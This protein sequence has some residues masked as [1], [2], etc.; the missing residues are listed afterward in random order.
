[1]SAHRP[2]AHRPRELLAALGAF[3]PDFFQVLA[4]SMV[5]NVLM[6]VPSIYM[7]QVYDR[8]L[9]SYSELTLLA[10]SLIALFLFGV[11]AMAEWL[12]SRL[13]VRSGVR[14]DR[15]LRG[16]VFEASFAAHATQSPLATPR[17]FSD[18]MQVRQFLTGS[19]MF[20]LLDA[21]WA[22][23]YAAVAWFLH[24]TLGLLAVVFIGVQ[25][26]V[27]WVSQQRT[28]APGEAAATA[29][30]DVNRFLHAKLRNSEVMEVLGMAEPLRR[31]WQERHA[32]ALAR[33]TASQQ[34]ADSMLA[35]SKFVR[36][37]LQAL[38]L[39]AGALLVIDG[40][41]SAGAMIAANLLIARA[42]A[43][44]DQLVAVWRGFTGTRL[45]FGRLDALL[46]AFPA[47]VATAVPAA[48][49]G[50]VKLRDVTARVPGREAPILADIALELA[51][52]TLTV[53]LGPSGSG[54]STLARVLLGAW[55]QVQGEVLLDGEPVAALDRELLA[56]HVG[57]LPQEVEL[58]AGT[59]AEN[60]ASG[61]EVDSD[62]AIEAAR[63]AGL[64]E[65]ILR[66]PRGY[67]TPVGQMGEVMSGGQRQRIALARALY[68]NP[69]F[70][71]LDE[72]NA[73]LDDAGEQA[74]HHALGQLKVAG[75][76]VLV[77]THRPG[78]IAQ[79]D[80]L[81][82]LKDGRIQMQGPP[83]TVLAAMAP[84]AGARPAEP[85]PS[86]PNSFQPA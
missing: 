59:V 63:T 86:A 18:L 42:L 46:R 34:A 35:V 65:M 11:M 55:P 24:P 4:L 81:V 40:E 15:Q 13:L 39:G 70:V 78:A 58:I 1:M 33:G 27:A 80:H 84:A 74:L 9:V 8:V 17:A 45:A 19:G 56:R 31:R 53:V 6:L 5:I 66:L 67:D 73:H 12:R 26:A 25:C 22:P 57:Y 79:A 51:P 14:F 36:Y 49:R 50:E 69:A 82:L 7:L 77:V 48:A 85:G 83:R 3:R 71:V 44:I 32:Q 52:G 68:G 38:S 62:L 75:R 47:R 28:A 41:L 60:I 37:S 61:G 30:G 76:T 10:V 43:P 54:K 29:V 72:P 16:R 64:H 21:P 2:P 23:I 20:A